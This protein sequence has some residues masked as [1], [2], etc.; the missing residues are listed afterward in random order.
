M[1]NEGVE[2]SKMLETSSEEVQS[3]K[4]RILN[5]DQEIDMLCRKN[6]TLSRSL[7]KKCEEIRKLTSENSELKKENSESNNEI[8]KKCLDCL[9]SNTTEVLLNN[10]RLKEEMCFVK[11]NSFIPPSTLEAKI[12][13][14]KQL[15]ENST[16]WDE[17]CSLKSGGAKIAE[18]HIYEAENTK[19]KDEI[20]PF[21]CEIISSESTKE[22]IAPKWRAVNK[23]V[24]IKTASEKITKEMNVK[25]KRPTADRSVLKCVDRVSNELKERTVE[26]N[27][28]RSQ[29]KEEKL[30][31]E[32]LRREVL[33][34]QEENVKLSNILNQNTQDECFRIA[35]TQSLVL[36]QLNNISMTEN[37][38]FLKAVSQKHELDRHTLKTETMSPSRTWT[39]E[40]PQLR[41][42]ECTNQM[43]KV[44]L[45]E[46][47]LNSLR[48]KV[49]WQKNL[50][51]RLQKR[52][53]KLKTNMEHYKRQEDILQCLKQENAF[54]KHRIV[55]LEV[56]AKHVDF[57][58]K[59]HTKCIQPV[60]SL[61]IENLML[62]SHPY[63]VQSRME[64]SAIQYKM[65]KKCVNSKHKDIGIQTFYSS[66]DSVPD[67]GHTAQSDCD[68]IQILLRR[69]LSESEMRRNDCEMRLE[70]V[71]RNFRNRTVELT[72]YLELIYCW[73]FLNLSCR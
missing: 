67:L 7:E 56:Q 64:N 35:D 5:Q 72:Q 21:S 13:G 29:R 55:L 45:Q 52:E 60:S 54:Q 31:A 30:Q 12:H 41:M 27:E 66:S 63:R 3:L 71:E 17:D 9:N 6:V 23:N 59:T 65:T 70:L 24:T 15:S 48:K 11:N 58:H 44:N 42:P 33:V 34:H 10:S 26:V 4:S 2:C 51:H 73:Q 46:W 37:V 16:Q 47:K 28:L 61:R 40:N 62:R 22:K 49:T 1:E 36:F 14:V 43:M 50:I 20:S 69:Q 53:L 68:V 57:V 25:V 32:N 8:V 18:L 19:L 39:S 38:N